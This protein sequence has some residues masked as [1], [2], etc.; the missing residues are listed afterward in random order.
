MIKMPSLR[1]QK[2]NEGEMHFLTFRVIE[3]IDVFTKPIYFESI[4]NSLK[5]CQKNKGLLLNAYVI[6]T[7]HLHVI[8]SA[9]NNNLSSI[10]RD[11]KSYT[12]NQL[13]KILLTDNREYIIRILRK[14]YS[15]RKGQKFQ[16]WYSENWSVL[17][18]SDKFLNQKLDYIHE[19]PVEKGYVSKPEEWIYSS[20]GNYYLDDNSIIEVDKV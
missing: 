10:V 7:N 4:I 12:T 5:Y 17:I 11:F 3:W 2:E 15:K 20:A 9:K 8:M 13:K 1:I 6:M 19:N 14:S 18:E 16:L